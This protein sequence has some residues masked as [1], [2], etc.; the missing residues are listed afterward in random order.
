M[1]VK[2]AILYTLANLLF[3][4]RYAL[5]RCSTRVVHQQRLGASVQKMLTAV[6]TMQHLVLD[7]AIGSVQKDV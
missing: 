7:G 2:F 4:G 5:T 3:I 6:M 1:P